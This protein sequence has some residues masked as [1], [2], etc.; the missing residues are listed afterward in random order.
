[1]DDHDTQGTDEIVCPHCGH[2]HRDSF[3][4]D[5]SGITECEACEKPFTYNREISITY[6]TEKL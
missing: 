2:E 5:D 6:S 3:E 4:F 1:M